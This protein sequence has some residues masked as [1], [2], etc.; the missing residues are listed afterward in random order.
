[1]NTELDADPTGDAPHHPRGLAALLVVGGFIGFAASFVLTID[2]LKLLK[3]PDFVPLCDISA[4]V[5]CTDVMKSDQS[6][7]FG[8]PNPLLG[9]VGFTIVITL[10]VVVWAGADL[11]EWVWGG[12]QVGTIAGLALIHWLAYQTLYEIGAL[13]PY[14]MIVW[15]VTIVIFFY[16]LL[17]N[18]RAWVPGSPITSFLRNGHLL[19]V[20]LWLIA[21]AAAILL[22]F[23]DNFFG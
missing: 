16:V 12:L 10:G 11:A 9:L 7:I 8:F 18:L 3:N 14:C 22:R 13:C 5:S 19:I 15:T 4:I 17:R 1:M 23:W 20:M 6:G 21:F 2:K